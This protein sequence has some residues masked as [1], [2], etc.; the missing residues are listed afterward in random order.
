MIR[1]NHAAVPPQNHPELNQLTMLHQSSR[2]FT[3]AVCLLAVSCSNDPVSPDPVVD[4]S[5][6]IETEV[7]DGDWYGSWGGGEQDGVVF[8]PVVAE[9]LIE[10]DHVELSG[11]PR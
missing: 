9:L 7:L 8:Q 4:S 11:F 3:T 5:P 2:V 6:A 10:G 1:T